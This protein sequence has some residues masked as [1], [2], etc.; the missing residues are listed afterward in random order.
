MTS[1]IAGCVGLF[2][3][4]LAATASATTVPSLTFEEMT[5][6]SELV[7]A[8]Q[9]SRVWS[10]W[11]S[12]H[13]YIWTHYEINVASTQKGAAG[14]TVVVSEPGGVVGDRALAIA[15][16]VGYSAGEQVAVFLERMP[17]GYLRTTGW[18]QGKFGVDATGHLHASAA[19]RGVELVNAG[20]A[21]R[22]PGGTSLRTLEG[23]SLVDLRS[24]VAARITNQGS[25]K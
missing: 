14:A 19:M 18:G 9:V 11:D 7:V 16:V 17:N 24:R 2:S 13:K 3:L 22:A 1:R 21:V 5:D 4:L 10:D 8:G 20:Q 6:R 15:G 25:T 12:G 23:I